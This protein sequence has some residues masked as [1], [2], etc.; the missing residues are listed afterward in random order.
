MIEFTTTILQFDQQGEKTGWTYIQVPADIAQKLKPGNKKS[1]RVKGKL[2]KYVIKKIALLPMG[3]GNFIMALNGEIRKGIR[4]G[5]GA[6][7]NVQLEVD[8]A[9]LII[10]PEL[11]ECLKDE[12]AALKQFQKMPNSHQH[13]YSKWIDSAKTEATKAKRIAITV[14][15]MVKGM[16]YGEMLRAARKENEQLGKK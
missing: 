6:M 2:D 1:F 12:P 10:S 16:D 7:L 13:Y 9:E 5:K 15:A 14:T 8:K 11:I 4:K 3:G